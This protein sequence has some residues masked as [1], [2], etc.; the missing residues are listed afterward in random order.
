MSRRWFAFV[1]LSVTFAVPLLPSAASAI[2]V[3]GRRYGVS[4]AQCHD[5]IPR[6]NAFGEMFAGHGLRMVA[7]ESPTDTIPTDDALLALGRTLPLAV[8]FDAHL[9]AYGTEPVESDFQAPFGLKLLS[10]APLSPSLSYYFYF[11]LAERGEVGG[12]EDAFLMWN[13]VGG[14]PFDLSFGQFQISDPLFKRELRLMFDDYAAYR[15]RMGDQ[16]ADLTYDRGFLAAFDWQGFTLTGEIVNGNGRGAANGGR[17]DDDRNKNLFGHVTRDIVPGLRV[18][19]MGYLGWQDRDPG[20]GDVRNEF[21]YAGVDATVNAGPVQV[22]GQ[23]LRRHDEAPT[24]DALEP[25]SKLDAGFVEFLLVPPAQRWYAFAL[26]NHLE[27]DRPI[28]DP[29]MGGPA[30]VDRYSSFSGGVGWLVQRNARLQVE[31][32]WDLELEDMRWTVSTI[33]AH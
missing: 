7:G 19:A 26:W 23:Y 20:A 16:Q 33:F 10:S 31:G 1:L 14:R 11:F 13:D 21:W 29:R 8:R 6:L 2:P 12:V 18:G 15:A 27:A 5:P 4:C 32:L 3:F 22:N 30:G 24:F 9:Q 28:L 25:D 17:F